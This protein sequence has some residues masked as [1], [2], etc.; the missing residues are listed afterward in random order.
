MSHVLTLD[1]PATIGAATHPIRA[2]ILAAMHEPATAAAAARA[3]G[4]SRQNAAYHVR[5]LLKAGL[6]RPAGSRTNGNFTEQYYEAVAPTMVIS[7]RS[8]WGADP[9]RAQALADQLSLDQLVAI[10][11][12]LQRDAA[13]LLDRAAFEGEE[14]PSASAT[15][16]IR[17]RSEADRAEFLREYIQ[18]VTSLAGRYGASSGEP[19]RLLLAAY[20]NPED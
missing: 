16:E 9:R 7:P 11:E 13:M 3:T 10:G 19:Y 12:Q 4:Q 17:F 6:I 5:E 2:T 20:P 18:A 14:I 8:T 15:T 1:D